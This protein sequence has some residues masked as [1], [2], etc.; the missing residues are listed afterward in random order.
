MIT[1]EQGRAVGWG[2]LWSGLLAVAIVSGSRPELRAQ[3]RAY[4]QEQTQKVRQEQLP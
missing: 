1:R 4:R 3:L 2:L